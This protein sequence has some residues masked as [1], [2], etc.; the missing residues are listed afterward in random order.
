MS[1]AHWLPYTTLKWTHV[2]AVSVSFIG[3]AARGIGALRGRDWVRHRLARVL[4]HLVDTVL[5]L[6]AL[7]M[8]WVLHLAPWSLPWLRAKLVGLVGYILL[9]VVALRPRIGTRAFTPRAVRLGSWLAALLVFG[10]IV[11]VA[12]TKNPRGALL[13]LR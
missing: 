9:G 8:L 12:L 2:T 4:P 1:P 13:L 6:S 11:S 7:G 5:L 3:F 10:Y